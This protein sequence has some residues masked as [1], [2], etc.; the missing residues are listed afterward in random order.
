M[1][2]IMSVCMNCGQQFFYTAKGKH[3]RYR[4]YCDPCNERIKAKQNS[5]RV[6]RFRKKQAQQTD[7]DQVRPVPSATGEQPKV[8]LY[9]G[10]KRARLIDTEKGIFTTLDP[11]LTE[12]LRAKFGLPRKGE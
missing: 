8:V 3:G 4:S 12:K 1:R 10:P 11:K 5:N 7:N 6:K 9:F 2:T